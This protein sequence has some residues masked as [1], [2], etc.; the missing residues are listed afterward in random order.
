MANNLEF[1]IKARDATGQ[2]F[3]SAKRGLADIADASGKATGSTQQFLKLSPQMLAIGTI[4]AGVAATFRTLYNASGDLQKSTSELGEAWDRAAISLGQWWG[5]SKNVGGAIDWVKDKLNAYAQLVNGVNKPLP[6]SDK[7]WAD[8][9]K[10]SSEAFEAIKKQEKEK[11]DLA[12]KTEKDRIEAAQKTRAEYLKVWEGAL[13]D[14][15]KLALEYNKDVNAAVE[16]MKQQPKEKAAVISTLLIMEQQYQDKLKAIRE[17]TFVGPDAP[18]RE[19][20]EKAKKAL[21]S[22]VIGPLPESDEATRARREKLRDDQ[23]KEYE[24]QASHGD[25]LVE[26]YEEYQKRKTS[27]AEIEEAR[28]Y[29]IQQQALKNTSSILGSLAILAD[30]HGRKAFKRS[31]RLARAQA[32]VDTISAAISAAKDTPG[33]PWAKFAAFAAVALNFGARMKQIN[34]VSYEGGGSVGGGGGGGEPTATTPNTTPSG[35][36]ISNQPATTPTVIQVQFYGNVYSVDDFRAAVADA[37]SQATNNDQVII[38]AN[39]AQARELM[40]A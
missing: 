34:S 36:P 21:E 2:A 4:T 17:K 28:R 31:Q 1:L 35:I 30:G 19:A 18:D 16:Y 33:G 37:V 7:E 14:E 11:K 29:A 9:Q 6:L 27:I 5:Q 24:L 12:E 10:R 23:E 26:L 40:R 32:T 25:A 3:A 39:S 8:I 20:L 38:Q 13:D 22:D 15:Q